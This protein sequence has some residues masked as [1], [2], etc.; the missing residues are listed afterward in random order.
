MRLV[1]ASPSLA[2]RRLLPLLLFPILLAGLALAQDKKKTGEKEDVKPKLKKPLSEEED[3]KV[4][5]KK[6]IKEEEDPKT[7]PKKKPITEDEDP[8]SKPKKPPSE[9]EDSKKPRK[10]IAD[11]ADVD[12]AKEAERTKH[13][14]LAAI[15]R[16]LSFAHDEMQHK[17]DGLLNIEPLANYI[18]DRSNSSKISY[19]QFVAPNKL[20]TA[21]YQ[22]G[23]GEVVK[24]NHFEEI[25]VK[26]AKDIL[27]RDWEKLPPG[28][29]SY[30]SRL[31]Q[32]VA[33]DKIL[34]FVLKFHDAAR[35]QKKRVGG[36]WDG[37]RQ[38]MREALIDVLADELTV[39]AEAGLN[40]RTMKVRAA[41]LAFRL[42]DSFTDSLKAQR[43]VVLWKL[44][45]SNRKIEERDEEYFA[46]AKTFKRLQDQFS[47]AEAKEFD[48]LRDRLRERARAHFDEAKRLAGM[49]DGKS[50]AL[51]QAEMSKEI[52]ADLPGLGD[53]MQELARDFRL[54]VVG[55]KRLPERMS[56]ALAFTNSERWAVEMLFESLVQPVPDSVV[57]HRF[58][59]QLSAQPPRIV[60]LG[61][62]F[63]LIKDAVWVSPNSPPEP[64]NA[65]AV[66]ETLRLLHQGKGLPASDGVDLLQPLL[67][68]DPYRFT[69]RLE[70]SCIEPLLPMTFKIQPGHRLAKSA[71]GLL[72]EEFARNPVGTGPFVY[73]GRRVE[74]GR[75][76]AVF[77]AN[78][79]YGKRA[80]LFGF[81]RIQEI[82]FV[83]PTADVAADLRN[84]KIDLML[85]VPTAEMVRLRAP[86][87]GLART[88][89][90][91]SLAS[92]RIWLLAV[93][94][95]RPALGGEPGKPLRRAIAHAIDREGILRDVFKA[96]TL[97][98][99]ILSGPFPNGTWATPESPP[100][101]YRL[102]HAETFAKQAKIPEQLVLRFVD[103]PSAN[104]ACQLIK[105]Q[106]GKVG[107]RVELA[108]HSPADFYKT[109]ML[110]H[111]YD[112]AYVPFDFAN[113][114]YWIG[115]LLDPDAKDRGERNFMEYTPERSLAQLL[116][117]MRTT[118]DFLDPIKGLR[119]QMQQF[120]TLFNEPMPFVPL[121][122]LDFHMLRNLNLD[123]VPIA[124]Q[125]DPLTIFDQVEGWRVNR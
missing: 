52:Y 103:D 93:N 3:P 71:Q 28:S 87:H 58:R 15:F 37:V 105:Q 68:Q 90:E 82:R 10:P 79:E 72:D 106:L 27:L 100:S 24:V 69:L 44:N 85:D 124:D 97:H 78:T 59:N 21:T 22:A 76:Y 75:E 40:D 92:R 62:E 113:E 119:R 118:R 42:G 32:L 107:I 8:K 16:R 50:A 67:V 6:P 1:P 115:G 5:P 102:E 66:K 104:A 25:A 41:D 94:H 49:P 81:P 80:G 61:R 39:T 2:V 88:I 20:G 46:A 99:S 63:E 86:E 7:K 65:E 70:R 77:K 45:Q 33:A 55:V 114:M 91:Y 30:L 83:V 54:I 123:T 11:D 35:A 12:L 109:V 9:T 14:E 34:T 112:L 121:W 48:S 38:R 36:E 89:K 13:K 122:Q 111:N 98:H 57:G 43:E 96:G 51:R 60:P 74:D 101:L 56:P 64:V 73:H 95:N 18:G 47:R 84:G 29:E 117:K 19:R 4:K 23:S 26:E 108:G 125:L 120:Y 53:F 31:D 116:Q 17:Q 110:E